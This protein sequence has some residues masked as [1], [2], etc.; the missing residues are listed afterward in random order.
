MNRI[1]KLVKKF[2]LQKEKITIR[3]IIINFCI[4]LIVLFVSYF[5]DDNQ[6]QLI[7][8]IGFLI[9]FFGTIV[10]RKHFMPFMFLSI[11][12]YLLASLQEFWNEDYV[13][14][15]VTKLLW[16]IGNLFLPIGI[17]HF[18]YRLFFKFE[19]VDNED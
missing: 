1:L 10:L 4:I 7:S 17:L 18:M 19:I 5:S 9:A 14:L 3:N 15:P 8:L 12:A 6:K 2:I 11:F 16:T 13:Y